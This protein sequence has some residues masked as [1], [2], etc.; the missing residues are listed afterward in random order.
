MSNVDKAFSEIEQGLLEKLNIQTYEKLVELAESYKTKVYPIDEAYDL[1]AALESKKLMN[2]AILT[3]GA[4]VQAF[5][6]ALEADVAVAM[7]SK[8]PVIRQIAQ[9]IHE[10]RTQDD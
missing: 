8:N 2:E 9:G 6:D 3:K 4:Q 7:L 5:A 1:G 10:S